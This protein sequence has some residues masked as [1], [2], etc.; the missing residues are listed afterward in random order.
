MQAQFFL[1]NP[2]FNL[3]T[4][5]STTQNLQEV[6]PTVQVARSLDEVLADIEIDLVSKSSPNGT[7]YDYVDKCLLAGKYV[8]VEKPFTI[9][10]VKVEELFL[11]ADKEGKVISVFPNRRCDSSPKKVKT[12]FNRSNL[13][14]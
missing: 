5:I 12:L 1:A 10:F 7:H 13:H 8:L 6:Y 14:P 2:N 9:T 4:I 3:K 11:I